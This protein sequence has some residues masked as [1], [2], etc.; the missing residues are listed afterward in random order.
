MNLASLLGRGALAAVLIVAAA[1]FPSVG[2]AQSEDWTRPF[3]PLRLIGNIYWV[4]S[5]DLSTYL[6][7]TPQG[8]ILINTGLGDTARQIKASVEQLGFTIAD[9][10]I[11]TATHGHY[12]HAAGLGDLK[13]MTGARLIVNDADRPLYETGG[14]ADYIFGRTPGTRFTPVHVDATFRNGGT[15]E[16]GGTT[17]VAHHH[18]GHTQGATSFTTTVRENGKDTGSSSR[19]WR[20]STPV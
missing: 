7:A 15:I 9:V 6:I 12:D 17:L 5:Y 4:G 1:L 11:L 20:R 13:T 10:K 16:L 14:R 19:T 18:P 2:T 3:P 8:H